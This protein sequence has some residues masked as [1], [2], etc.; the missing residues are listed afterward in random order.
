MEEPGVRADQVRRVAMARVAK[1]LVDEAIAQDRICP[2]R[3]GPLATAI[4]VL[5]ARDTGG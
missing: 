4:R 2:W 3:A 1:P 5:Q